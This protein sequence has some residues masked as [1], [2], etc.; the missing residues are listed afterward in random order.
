VVVL[1]DASAGLR[2]RGTASSQRVQERLGILQIRRIKPF[3]EP[4]IHLCQHL[5]RFVAFPLLLP[6]S[7]QAGGSTEFSGFGLLALGYCNG[8]LETGCGFGVVVRILL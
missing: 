8:L 6:E 1:T 5:P 4:V 2:C 3:G 7:S